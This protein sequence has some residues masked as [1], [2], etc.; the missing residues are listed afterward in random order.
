MLH[1]CSVHAA[2]RCST[3]W[4][5]VLQGNV[6]PNAYSAECS[7]KE[8][9]MGIEKSTGIDITTH[10]LVQYLDFE[11]SKSMNRLQC[12]KHCDEMMLSPRKHPATLSGAHR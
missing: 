1:R 8:Q 5:F 2:S 3:L 11:Q 9:R 4:L 6:M 10:E 12:E 7:D